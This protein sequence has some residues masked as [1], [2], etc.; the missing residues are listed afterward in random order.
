[1]QN[2]LLSLKFINLCFSQ[3]FHRKL[4]S[5]N[6]KTLHYSNLALI[7]KTSIWTHI[8]S[9]CSHFFTVKKNIMKI[10]CSGICLANVSF[11]KTRFCLFYGGRIRKNSLILFG[12]NFLPWLNVFCEVWKSAKKPASSE[13]QTAAET[14]DL[15]GPIY[16]AILGSYVHVWICV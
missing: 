11:T 4:K 8:C 10:L 12:K 1:M 5:L 15:D 7:R 2:I 13:D 9:S 16:P 6:L 14:K 3:S